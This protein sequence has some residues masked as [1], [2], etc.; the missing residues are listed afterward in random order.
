M[1][2]RGAGYRGHSRHASTANIGRSLREGPRTVNLRATSGSLA[3]YVG[4]VP[5]EAARVDE[6]SCPPALGGPKH[7]VCRYRRKCDHI[8]HPCYG[9]LGGDRS[10]RI[11]P[12]SLLEP[13]QRI[14]FQFFG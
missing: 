6:P 3:R 5:S 10:T 14:Q 11:G 9:F 7:P 13:V 8:T 4:W 1:T 12:C 2:A